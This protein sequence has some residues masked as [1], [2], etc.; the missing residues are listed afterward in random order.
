[1]DK[2][3]KIIATLGPSIYSEHKLKKLVDLGVDAFRI[4]FSHN[5]LG[6]Q[7]TVSKIRR[8]EKIS[9]KKIAL[10]A[11]LQGVKLRIGKIIN[12]HKLIKFNQK[13]IFD[14]KKNSRESINFP[15]PNIIKKI[16][17]NSKILIDDGKFSFKV[18]SKKK[19]FSHSGVQ[20]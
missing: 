11:D 16:K 9:N 6:I 13:I 12:D 10:I 14:N 2:K 18:I 19:K 4:N 17:K 5:T 15:Y 3:A 7:K 8:V 1:M 20:N